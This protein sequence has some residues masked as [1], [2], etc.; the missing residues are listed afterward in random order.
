[1]VDISVPELVLCVRF[2]ALDRNGSRSGREDGFFRFQFPF[3][4]FLIH[5]FISFLSGDSIEVE[6]TYLTL[7]SR[8]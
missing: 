7:E 4:F 3:F 5:T 6:S 2:R 1:M 8:Q